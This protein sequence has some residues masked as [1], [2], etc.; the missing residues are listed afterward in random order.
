MAVGTCGFPAGGERAIGDAAAVGRAQNRNVTA[1][2]TVKRVVWRDEQNP[3]RSYLGYMAFL[4]DAF[5]L[6]GREEQSGIDAAL[7]VP[8]AAVCEI[9]TCACVPVEPDARTEIMLDLLGGAPIVLRPLGGSEVQTEALAR[10]LR[11]AI[12]P[13]RSPAQSYEA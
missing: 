3:R 12:R 13:P 6:A 8:H 4:D 11:T 7:T 10:R 2:P 5:R 9:R 1:I